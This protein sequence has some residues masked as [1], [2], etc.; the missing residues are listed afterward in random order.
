MRT[1]FFLDY[2]DGR[3][4]RFT[5]SPGLLPL[6][7][8]ARQSGFDV[9]FVDAEDQLLAALDDH[10]VKVVAISSMERLLPRSIRTAAQVR[11]RRPDVVLMLGGNAIEAFATELTASVFDVV[12]TGEGEHR[13]V[14]MLA[15]IARAHGEPCPPASG[16]TRLP[17]T[18]HD[19]GPAD[20]GG[21]IDAATM[22]CLTGATFNRDGLDIGIGGVYL[23]NADTGRVI[24]LESPAPSP[25]LN[26]SLD[27]TPLADELDEFCIYPWDE[28]DPD[29]W[30]TFEFYTQ[31]GCRWGRCEF[32]SVADRNI[33]AISHDHLIEVLV[34]AA[35]RGV[36]TVSFSDDLF[37][38][39]VAWN[40]R[41]LERLLPLNLGLKY[42]AQTMANR[43]V[44]PL[45]DLMRD[46]GFVEL[47]FGVETLIAERARFMVKSYDGARY[48]AGA[49]ETIARVA[50][51]GI[52]PILYLIMADP[53]ST[54]TEIAEEL[55]V[56]VDF[57]A[58]VYRRTGVVPKTS[59]SL[60][61]LPVAGPAMTARHSYS[62]TDVRAGT[63]TIRF[64][65]EFHFAPLVSRYL[66]EI[67]STTAA[68]P[69]RRE[70][71]DCLP[72][73][74]RVARAAAA[75]A[76]PEDRQAIEASVERG[77]RVYAALARELDLD[78]ES[79]ARELTGEPRA[80]A[81]PCRDE[82]RFEFGRF[83]GYIAGVQHYSELLEAAAGAR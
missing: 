16:A 20:P 81:L 80:R 14:P 59:Y 15:A 4:G 44:W 40:R 62:T 76:A 73:Y 13:F 26:T 41:L 60:A 74:L 63:R 77:L 9:A 21:A 57:V 36:K 66:T 28:I 37:V 12:S 29:R 42:R 54:L 79:T 17:A 5:N 64:P 25:G 30:P 23:R 22:A 6:V 68:L 49:V 31:R 39:D 24:M 38:Q 18:Q 55:A 78:V 34:E 43:S 71:L 46:V 75:G 65:E 72:I 10:R 69:F 33:R 11:A 67:A 32:C 82:L 27:P 56:T 45:L 2:D 35:R 52:C 47:S 53:R 50:E 61:M 8:H 19:L 48:V 70:N 3:G 51:A 83:G 1:L 7:G 58:Q